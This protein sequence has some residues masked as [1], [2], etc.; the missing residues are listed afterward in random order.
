LPE[1]FALYQNYPNPFNPS[2]TISFDLKQQS[3]VTLQIYNVLGQKV[4]EF[5]Y[6]LVDAGSYLKQISLAKFASGIYLYRID[7]IGNSGEH[8]VSTKRM[9]VMK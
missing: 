3:T 9:I 5:S 2:T 1:S 8:F 7:A 4:E 6:G